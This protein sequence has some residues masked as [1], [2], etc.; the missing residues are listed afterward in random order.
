MGNLDFLIRV[1]PGARTTRIVSENEYGRDNVRSAARY[2]TK[3]GSSTF[4]E[5]RF[6]AESV[7]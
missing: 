1:Q 2:A 4:L 6:N 5:G 7:R 3:S